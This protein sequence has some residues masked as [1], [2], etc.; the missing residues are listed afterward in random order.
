MDNKQLILEVSNSTGLT[1]DQ[2]KAAVTSMFSI[3]S[4]HVCSG[5]KCKVEINRFGKFYNVVGNA[6]SF[7]LA[8]GKSTSLGPVVIMK[9]KADK[10]LKDIGVNFHADRVEYPVRDLIT[11]RLKE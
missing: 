3:I 6:G 8:T 11:E 1:M 9:F 4:D 10:E 7:S 2:A 5:P